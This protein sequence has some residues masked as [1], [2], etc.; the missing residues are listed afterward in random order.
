MGTRGR[1]AGGHMTIG[2]GGWPSRLIGAH[3]RRPQAAGMSSSTPRRTV[4][5]AAAALL[6]IGSLGMAGTASAATP[7]S[8]DTPMIL[9]SVLPADMAANRYGACTSHF[10][11]V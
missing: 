11:H 10:S 3:R 5:L 2:T 1:V 7:Y 8:T 9:A 6:L 4:P